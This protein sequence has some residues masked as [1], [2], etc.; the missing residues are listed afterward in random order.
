MK[1]FRKFLSSPKATAVI[2]GAA[3]ALLLF[4]SIGGARAALEIRSQTHQTQIETEHIA[5]QLLEAD[6]EGG[7]KEVVTD[8]EFTE[9]TTRKGTLSFD[10]LRDD[11]GN[12][13]MTAGE[14]Y[15]EVLSVKNTGEINQYTRVTIYKY[16]VDD[17]GDKMTNLWP[18]YIELTLAEGWVVDPNASTPER[19]VVYYKNI[20]ESGEKKDLVTSM[21]IDPEVIKIV[22]EG[23]REYQ[24]HSFQI[25]VNVDAVQTHHAVDA[26]KSAWGCNVVNGSAADPETGVLQT[27]EFK[28]GE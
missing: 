20:L 7:S 14:S 12:L 3:V 17:K 19:T 15:P 27:L 21:R 10:V 16:W 25:E 23:G 24:D 9:V 28:F 1:K 6:G 5:V 8:N 22:N 2:F 4:S 26:I 13:K 11:T 18:G